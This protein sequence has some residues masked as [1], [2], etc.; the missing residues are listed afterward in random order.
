M[1]TEANAIANMTRNAKQFSYP[2]EGFI[3]PIEHSLLYAMIEFPK[4]Y[5]ES[6][7]KS[8][9]EEEEFDVYIL[10]AIERSFGNVC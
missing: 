9:I 10:C 2:S 8:V 3:T 7:V 6:V 5:P 1:G 4:L